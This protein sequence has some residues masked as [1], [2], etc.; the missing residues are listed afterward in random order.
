LR[1]SRRPEKLTQKSDPMKKSLFNGM[2]IIMM[3]A[4]PACYRD[5]F[6]ERKHK[7]TSMWL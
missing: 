6:E 7:G 3:Q 5:I 4:I 1:S 2:K